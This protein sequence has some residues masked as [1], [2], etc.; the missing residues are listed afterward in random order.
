MLIWDVY[1]SPDKE[2]KNKR[3]KFNSE[4]LIIPGVQG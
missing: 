1:L 2:K 4:L 3:N